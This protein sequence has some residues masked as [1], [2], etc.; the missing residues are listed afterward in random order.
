MVMP[1]ASRSMAQ[2]T[3]HMNIQVTGK[4]IDIGQALASHVRARLSEEISKYAER[5]ISAQATFSREGT[6]FR[7]DC[8]VHLPGGTI[9][10]TQGRAADIYASFGEAAARL[11]KRLRRLKR[12]LTAHHQRADGN[13]RSIE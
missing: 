3:L 2:A 8:S 12:R 10:Q 5:A 13:S 1:G 7:A 11:E 6:G 9:V 4:Q